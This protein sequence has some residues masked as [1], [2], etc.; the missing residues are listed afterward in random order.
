M[1]LDNFFLVNQIILKFM[2]HA[3][4]VNEVR[5]IFV[6]DAD[7]TKGIRRSIGVPEM[8]RYLRVESNLDEDHE[9]KEM[10]L[11]SSI[12]DIK[13]NTHTLIRSQL[14]KIK[15]L[16]KMWLVHQIDA[17]KVF[18]EDREEDVDEAWKFDVLKPCLGIV[19]KFLK[20]E[21]HY[22]IIESE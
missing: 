2:L 1:H 14:D 17:T 4:L 8:H 12:E 16:N 3:G 18:N 13:R 6:P 7:Y 15:R 10:I 22:M 11:Q 9:P 5:Q 21:D 19:R 20:N